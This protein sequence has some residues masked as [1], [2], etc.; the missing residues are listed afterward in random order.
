MKLHLGC[1]HRY[2]SG[3]VHID[4]CDMPYIDYKTSIDNLSIIDDKNVEL[5]YNSHS[6]EYFDGE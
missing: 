4:L 1:W 3:F 2:I 5:I 6:F